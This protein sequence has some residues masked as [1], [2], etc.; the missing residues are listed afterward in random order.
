MCG[1]V[2]FSGKNG[3]KSKFIELCRQSCIRGVHAFGIA[4]YD[5]NG[6]T[7]HKS[8]CFEK[9]IKNIPETLPE[10]IIFH[11]R[12]STS[13]DHATMENNQPI[14]VNNGA[15]VF[16]GTVNMGTK[17][18]M[19]RQNDVT[20]QTENDGELVLLDIQAGVPFRRLQNKI[21]TFAGIY[22]DNTGEMFAFR[23]NMRPLYVFSVEG[24]KWLA[25]TL[26]IAT[27]AKFDKN[28]GFSVEPFKLLSL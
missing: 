9:L 6:L 22:L 16:N 26:D 14:F 28:N 17:E 2:G 7:V 12:Y 18:E 27:R 10:K 20:L 8:L 15:L 23:N 19:E 25:S 21:V 4:Y 11:N 24:N 1:I 3:E 5:R 13:G